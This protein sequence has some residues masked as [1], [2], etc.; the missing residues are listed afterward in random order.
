MWPAPKSPW[1]FINQMSTGSVLSGA[2]VAPTRLDMGLLQASAPLRAC[3]L[4][5]SEVHQWTW[6]P[7]T[8]LL[9][10]PALLVALDL[11]V[12]NVQNNRPGALRHNFPSGLPS[13]KT[14]S[15]RVNSE[16]SRPWAT[17]GY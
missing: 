15:F 13:Q 10:Q 14:V 12:Q 5:H 7:K 3:V 9:L 4:Q 6:S 2:S 11:E 1:V 17:E 8:F 16:C